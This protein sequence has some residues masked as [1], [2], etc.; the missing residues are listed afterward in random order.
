MLKLRRDGKGSLL[1]SSMGKWG[2]DDCSR[3][4]ECSDQRARDMIKKEE[5][6]EALKK[7]TK[8]TRYQWKFGSIWGKW[9]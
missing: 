1:N 2:G 5:I 3:G 8:G 4:R 7:M 6:R 9:D